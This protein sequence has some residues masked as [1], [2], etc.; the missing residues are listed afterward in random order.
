MGKL[1]DQEKAAI[2]TQYLGG[3]SVYR[4]ARVYQMAYNSIRS[5][6][7]VRKVPLRGKRRYEFDES[8]FDEVDSETKAYWLGFLYA[9]GNLHRST[10]SIKLASVDQDHLLAFKQ[11][12]QA[13]QPL[14]KVKDKDAYVLKICSVSLVPRLNRLG[15][16]P[17]KNARL[18]FPTLPDALKLH[19]VR[20]FF[21][22]DGWFAKS[23]PKDMQVESWQWAV[24]SRTRKFLEKIREV[25]NPAIGRPSAGSFVKR[26]YRTQAG[27]ARVAWTLTYGGNPLVRAI[28]DA[29]YREATLFLRRKFDES[30]G[31]PGG[32]LQD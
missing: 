10:L 26:V 7:K 4:L 16:F 22:G 21:D 12:L 19:F 11:A 14:A 2:V 9:E 28:R 27:E 8:F 20:G 5:I 18:R 24:C 29:L 31:I 30:Q 17:N 6:L 23:K 1:T 25:I 15:I 3:C 13:Q 32:V